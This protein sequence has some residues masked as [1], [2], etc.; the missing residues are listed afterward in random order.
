MPHPLPTDLPARLRELADLIRCAARSSAGLS[1]ERG[2]QF[3]TP[4]PVGHGAGDVTFALDQATEAA[5]DAWFER[6]AGDGPL[7]LLTEDRGWRHRGPQGALDSF[8]HGGPRVVVDPVDGTRQL[9][10]DLRSAWT[11]IAACGPGA[12][13]PC[14]SDVHY[15]LCAELS[16][17]RAASY[18]VLS[19]QRGAGAR[20]E[21]RHLESDELLDE[22]PLQVD[23]DD[24]PDH[25]YFSF[26]RYTPS[27]RPALAETE[28]HFFARLAEHEGADVR[29]CYDDQYISNGGQLVLLSLGTYRLIA[30]LR[31]ELAARHATPSTTSKPYDCAGAILI[32]RAAGC[33]LTDA[34]SGPL[35][36]PLDAETPVSFIGWANRATAARLGPHLEGV[37]GACAGGRR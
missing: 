35:D 4:R 27:L 6:T 14:L 22:R 31:A 30:D 20:L 5:V 10:A 12:E 23:G 2:E 28:A 1:R 24:R 18:R 15:G 3:A 36:F 26:F 19:A 16:D 37:L 8:D 13:T 7:S 17:S 29:S 32:A 25:G 11:V 21:L 33:V 34:G 9:M